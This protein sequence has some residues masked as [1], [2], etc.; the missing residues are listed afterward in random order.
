MVE[1]VHIIMSGVRTAF[2]CGRLA[3]EIRLCQTR[4]SFSDWYRC[5]EEG[6]FIATRC[7]Q[8][9]AF[10]TKPMNALP[11]YIAVEPGQV[12]FE[13]GSEM[14]SSVLLRIINISLLRIAFRIR[15]NAPTQY[16]VTP[17]AGF[18]AA[19]E[20]IDVRVTNPDMS[21]YHRRHRFMVQAMKVN[22]SDK[23]RRKIWNSPKADNL[24]VV[25]CIRLLTLRTERQQA[26]TKSKGFTRQLAISPEMKT[27]KTEVT[28]VQGEIETNEER[29]T[30]IDQLNRQISIK[31]E[32][33]RR[34]S[35]RLMQAVNEVKKIEVELD[36][37]TI[38]KEK[39]TKLNVI[40]DTLKGETTK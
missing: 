3:A 22:E 14:S 11:I 15:S 37:T 38:I 6:L 28:S 24:D 25:Q 18:L 10:E 26:K 1:S 16:I 33:T 4:T 12:T 7:C 17:A 39:L 21:R 20:S 9:S 35:Q 32:E 36:K 31:L 30:K 19:N 40:L 13:D 29:M 2:V 34:E 8:M 27:G 23:D 5:A